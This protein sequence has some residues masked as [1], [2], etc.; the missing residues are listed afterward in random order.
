MAS[1]E[2]SEGSLSL[3]QLRVAVEQ[4]AQHL[5][6]VGTKESSAALERALSVLLL[7]ANASSAGAGAAEQHQ[8]R[9]VSA[10]TPDITSTPAPGGASEQAPAFGSLTGQHADGK[11]PPNARLALA[12]LRSAIDHLPQLLERQCRAQTLHAELLP[13]TLGE[14]GG[15]QRLLG[16]AGSLVRRRAGCFHGTGVPSYQPH[17]CTAAGRG[18]AG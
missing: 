15:L 5:E 4:A 7:A 14:L 10:D 1:P 6:A 8:Q 12:V 13:S 3:S 18:R 9:E 2:L 11:A 17:C 16:L